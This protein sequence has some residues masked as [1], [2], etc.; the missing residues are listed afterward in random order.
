HCLVLRTTC[1]AEVMPFQESPT[2]VPTG[3]PGPIP[4][5]TTRVRWLMVR[6]RPPRSADAELGRDEVDRLAD[7]LHRF[8]LFLRDLDAPLFFECEHGL[9]EVERIG[10]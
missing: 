4:V 8:H 5:T 1:R 9:H 6:S 3:V 2:P 10:V 7:R